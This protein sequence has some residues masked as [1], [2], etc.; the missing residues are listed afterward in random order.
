LVFLI[1][2]S[3]C[4]SLIRKPSARVLDRVRHLSADEVG[5][6]AITAAELYHG[7]ALSRDPEREFT[8]VQLLLDPLRIIEFGSQAAI[9]YGIVRASLER[10][11]TLIGPIDMLI[12]GHAVSVGATL[13]T[14]NTREFERVDGLL[15]EDWIR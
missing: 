2:T 14:Q 9:A 3:T 6:S 13:V 10:T 4:V 5:V 15:V 8:R 11:G 7:A 12:A 1:E